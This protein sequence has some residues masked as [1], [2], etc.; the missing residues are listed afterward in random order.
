M[1]VCGLLG[2]FPQTTIF[3]FYSLDV[4]FLLW[5]GQ[6]AHAFRGQ[7]VACIARGPASRG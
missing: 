2:L 5:V 3:A 6:R 7:L 4:K 1:P